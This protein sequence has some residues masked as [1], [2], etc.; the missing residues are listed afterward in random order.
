M[1]SLSHFVLLIYLFIY[2]SSSCLLV[3][4][5][6]GSQRSVRRSPSKRQKSAEDW[7]TRKRLQRHTSDYLFLHG[8]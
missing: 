7:E 2:V 5:G 1:S 4:R 8:R 6:T 3:G